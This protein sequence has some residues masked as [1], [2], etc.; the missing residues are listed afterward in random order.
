MKTEVPKQSRKEQL[1]K[2]NKTK[3]TFLKFLHKTRA[4]N[5]MNNKKI[6]KQCR[7]ERVLKLTGVPRKAIVQ[8]FGEQEINTGTPGAS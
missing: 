1:Q 6:F 5:Q 2:E 7:E 3:P 4:Q 8:A